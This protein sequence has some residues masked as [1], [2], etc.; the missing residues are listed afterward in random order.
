L[1]EAINDP[2]TLAIVA[3]NGGGYLT[4]I[5]PHV[6]F[7]P[8]ETRKT[9]LTVMGFSE[10][11]ALLNV[12]AGYAGGGGIYW[13]CPHFL[14]FRVRPMEA[15][16]KAFGAFWRTLPALLGGD[17]KP[18]A[19]ALGFTP[20]HGELVAGR[21]ESGPI[22]V[23]GG[24]LSVIVTLLGGELSKRVRPE[25]AWLAIEDINEAPY[26][27]DRYL[28]SMKIAGWFERIAGVLVGDFHTKEEPDQ[29][30][31]VVE[32]LRFH[33]PVGREVPVVLTRS[34]GHTWPITPMPINR[35]LG[36]TVR[37]REV[38]IA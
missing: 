9:P 33:L 30:Q 5:L 32:L 16:V 36:L 2:R 24:C 25:G 37:G 11:T 15:G 29:Q 12:V 3:S 10:I 18:A 27:I 7:S 14:A 35:T 13:L 8:L 31:A 19:E 26:R 38:E 17:G 4:R 28:A 34:F 20:L 6:D 23:M 22:R 1:Q 21:A